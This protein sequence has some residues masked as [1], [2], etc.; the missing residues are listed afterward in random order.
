MTVRVGTAAWAIPGTWRAHFPEEGTQLIRYAARLPVAEINSSFHRH[1]KV[2]TYAR[3]AASVGPDFRFAVK[4]PKTITHGARLHEADDD[5]RRF[6]AEVA[7]LGEKLGVILVQ[8]PPSLAFEPDIACAFFRQLHSLIPAQVACEPRHPSWFADEAETLLI[9][10]H[11]ARVAADPATVPAA[12][13]PGGW[14]GLAYFR[15]HG[16]PRIYW[17]SYD[18]SA[19]KGHARAARRALDRAADV[20]VIYD[21]TASGAATGNALLLRHLLRSGGAGS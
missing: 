17:S 11:V 10:H 4:L 21:N 15:L 14:D 13:R 20:W 16:A 12:A 7:G 8:L 1:H 19:V 9:D 2:A 6:A 3:W 18:D 5:L